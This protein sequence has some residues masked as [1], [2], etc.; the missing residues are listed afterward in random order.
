MSAQESNG[1]DMDVNALIE[2]SNSADQLEYLYSI[3]ETQYN[4]TTQNINNHA[5]VLNELINS[6]LVLGKE[7][8]IKNGSLVINLGNSIYA[9]AKIENTGTMLVNIG[10]NYIAEKSIEDAK[11]FIDKKIKAYEKEIEFLNKGRSEIRDILFKITY[12]LS[13][14]NARHE[15]GGHELHSK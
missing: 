15:H 5:K 4:N 13:E 11:K 12:K 14:L 9:N 10:L 3:Y 6:S 7:E 8:D 1:Q 2:K